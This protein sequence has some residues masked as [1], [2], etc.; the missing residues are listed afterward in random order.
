[1]LVERHTSPRSHVLCVA[2]NACP[3]FHPQPTPIPSRPALGILQLSITAT[4]FPRVPLAGSCGGGC[5]VT[6]RE[7]VVGGIPRRTGQRA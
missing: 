2:T 7:E 3:C 1:M 5:W 4:K 6:A